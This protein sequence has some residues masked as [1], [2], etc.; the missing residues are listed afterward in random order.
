MKNQSKF[1]NKYKIKKEINKIYLLLIL[2]QIIMAYNQTL[3]IIVI[4]NINN[5]CQLL[6]RTS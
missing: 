3:I 4:A 6:I 2:I 5:L 1:S